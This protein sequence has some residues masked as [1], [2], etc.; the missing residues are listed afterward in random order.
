M[1]VA[2]TGRY[3]ARHTFIKAINGYL[4]NSLPTRTSNTVYAGGV[5]TT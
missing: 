5:S 1:N 3:T 4:I 2:P